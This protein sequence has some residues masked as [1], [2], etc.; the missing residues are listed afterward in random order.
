[1]EDKEFIIK[2]G[3]Y[4]GYNA[5]F[6]KTYFH[7]NYYRINVV[8]KIVALTEKNIRPRYYHPILT[9]PTILVPEPKLTKIL[10]HRE[11]YNLPPLRLLDYL[12]QSRET[13]DKNQPPP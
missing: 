6:Y 1:M 13:V 9:T 12:D 5:T 10:I 8:D 11:C 7:K 3:A 2:N 4:K